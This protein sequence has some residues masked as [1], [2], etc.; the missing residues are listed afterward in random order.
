MRTSG[1]FRLFTVAVLAAAPAPTAFAQAQNPDATTHEEVVRATQAEKAESL[2]PYV[3]SKGEK[4]MDRVQ[5][6]VYNSTIKWHPFFESAYHGGGFTLGAGYMTHVSPYNTLDIR[7]S[8]SILSY[9]RA[10]AEFV[11]P[12]LFDRR[13]QL[14]LLGGW[15]E[16]TQVA[17]YGFG[18]DSSSNNRTNF[19]FRQPYA[20]ATLDF[21]PTRRYLM[22]RGGAEWSKWSLRP[23]EG[24]FPSVEEV[25]TPQTLPGL[26]TTTTYLHS[27]GTVGFDWRTASGYSR[28][29]G[30]YGVTG[31]DYYDR[32]SEFGFRQ[33]DY[34]AIQHFPILRETWVISLHGLAT[35]TSDKSGQQTPFFMMP[36]LGS[37]STLR[38]FSS[39]RFRDR[40]SLLLQA[41]W[42]I[43][44]NR[45]FESAVFYD[46]GKVAA[47]K[48]DLDFNGLKNDY[49]FGVRFHTPFFT[50]LRAE[51]ARS[52]EGTVF[53]FA[54]S[55]AF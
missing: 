30:F 13:A 3:P 53:V 31:H 28:R 12:R 1:L 21:R 8:Y 15:R 43:M 45:F 2:H 54:T 38:G 47:H 46:A 23:G 48:G 39:Q 11:A 37:G 17:F 20:S 29:G 16:A 33:M 49:G 32:D 25:Y 18:T 42:R 36:T 35:T 6:I 51:V 10:E 4:V 34:E 9:K 44:A 22:L 40:N 7:G 26:G 27:Q 5:D 19:N 14:S 41:E 55:P 52:K 24:S 50:V